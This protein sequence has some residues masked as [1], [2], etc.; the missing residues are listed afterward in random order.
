MLIRRINPRSSVSICGRPP[1]RCDFQ[2]QQQRA[3]PVPTHDRLGLNDCENLQDRWNPAIK[4]DK[5]P[6]IIVR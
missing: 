1:R 4:L 3:G 5:E 6:A 2:R